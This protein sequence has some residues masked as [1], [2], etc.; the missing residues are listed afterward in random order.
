MFA[1]LA[2]IGASQL[3]SFVGNE[4]Q[5]STDVNQITLTVRAPM[6]ATYEKSVSV[7]NDIDKIL[8]TYPEVESTVVKIGE[9]GLQ[10]ITITTNLTDRTQRRLSDKKLAQNLDGIDV[11]V[12][13]HSHH[14]LNGVIPN[15]NYYI[16]SIFDKLH[17][18]Y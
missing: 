14:T 8:H 13:G 10:N 16:F 18:P 2:L 5:P 15:E 1:V 7:A 11:I 12:G 3:M 4:F 9:R 17:I 6:G